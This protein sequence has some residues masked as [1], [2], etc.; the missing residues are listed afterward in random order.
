MIASIGG[1]S[2]DFANSEA[3]YVTIHVTKFR[4]GVRNTGN[5][6]PRP[7]QNPS[8]GNDLVEAMKVILAHYRGEIELSG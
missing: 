7:S 8:F 2:V 1:K 5:G 4:R 3:G 6:M